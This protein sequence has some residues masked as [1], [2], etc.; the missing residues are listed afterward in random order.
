[1]TWIVFGD[2]WGRHPSTTQHLAT[3][4]GARHRVIWIDSLA[5]R[6]PRLDAND[7]RRVWGR[8]SGSRDAASS[9]DPAWMVRPRPRVLPWHLSPIVAS[10]NRSAIARAVRGAVGH[11]RPV[12]LASNPVAALYLDGLPRAAL[13]YLRLDDY[14]ELPGVDPRLARVAER[15]M[16]E[17]ADVVVGTARRLLPEGVPGLYLPQGVDVD[18]FGS[19]PLRVPEAKVLGF[20]GLLAPWIDLDLVA[21]VARA[22]PDWTLELVGRVDVDVA[23]L[24]A[25]PNVRV[26]PAV[27]YAELPRA[28][29]GW[30]AAWAPFRMNELTA[31]VNPLK[32]REYLAAGLPTFCTPLPEV[33]GIPGARLGLHVED[34]VSWLRWE[35]ETD[36]P[37][38]RKVRRAGV[39]GD[40]WEARALTLERALA[41]V[42]SGRPAPSGPARS[43]G[44]AP[45]PALATS[46]L[47]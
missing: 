28:M 37:A 18:H 47:E 26:L 13:A 33:R 22:A 32:V 9:P 45:A 11:E 8:L 40:S 30:R 12:I 46:S 16:L 36:S 3:R 27:P 23:P 19:V 29:A 41:A 1:M 14:A 31:A 34:V 39:A 24:L 43:S 10:A 17:V 6:A 25:L 15:R 44:L 7:A 4:L 2:D 42:A 21:A 35:A 5:M 38:V 20:F